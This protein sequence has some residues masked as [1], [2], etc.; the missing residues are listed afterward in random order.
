MAACAAGKLCLANFGFMDDRR[1]G[2]IGEEAEGSI[3]WV[4]VVTNGCGD[5]SIKYRYCSHGDDDTISMGVGY[6]NV[7]PPIISPESDE[8]KVLGVSEG[9]WAIV[10]PPT[11]LPAVT[12]SDEGKV[13]GVNSSGDWDKLASV[14]NINITIDSVS[15]YSALDAEGIN[16]SLRDTMYAPYNLYVN[17]KPAYLEYFYYH[18]P[19]PV[20]YSDGSFSIIV[21]HGSIQDNGQVLTGTMHISALCT[22][23]RWD[24]YPITV[25]SYDTLPSGGSQGQ[26]L[27]KA[28]SS[29]FDCVW[30]NESGGGGGDAIMTLI[31]IV[32]AGFNITGIADVDGNRISFLEAASLILEAGSEIPNRIFKLLMKGNDSDTGVFFD[33]EAYVTGLTG[34]SGDNTTGTITFKIPDIG[35]SGLSDIINQL[36]P[37]RFPVGMTD[38]YIKWIRQH[39]DQDYVESFIYVPACCSIPTNDDLDAGTEFLCWNVDRLEFR[40]PTDR[41]LDFYNTVPDINYAVSLGLS[42]FIQDALANDWST[43]VVDMSGNDYKGQ[44]DNLIGSTAFV[45]DMSLAYDFWVFDW[46]GTTLPFRVINSAMGIELRSMFV[47]P[48]QSVGIFNLDIT[49]GFFGY[50]DSDSQT[51]SNEMIVISGTSTPLSSITPIVPPAPPS[52]A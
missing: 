24:V 7:L 14:N 5:G 22:S 2:Y 3:V 1:V 21:P 34:L 44:F 29:D 48:V 18:D 13:L 45:G 15:G 10:N 39:V 9:E 49:V 40:Y 33:S 17:G 28:S 50:Y 46:N 30:A 35:V 41:F 20:S 25:D 42:A 6:S 47:Y 51:Y 38:L 12:A 8:G 11:E 31:P 27:K 36:D 19:D 23:N 43:Q 32:D 4:S 52:N 16:E 26:V 37:G